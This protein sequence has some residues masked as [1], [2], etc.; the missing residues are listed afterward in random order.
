M[1]NVGGGFGGF[2]WSIYDWI[3]LYGEGWGLGLEIG[4]GFP[5]FILWIPWGLLMRADIGGLGLYLA[6]GEDKER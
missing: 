5:C 3:V 4:Q 6:L 2:R 1:G